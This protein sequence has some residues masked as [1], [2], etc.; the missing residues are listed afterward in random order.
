MP[1]ELPEEF[2]MRDLFIDG[3]N[4]LCHQHKLSLS[5]NR[6]PHHRCPH[7]TNA[8]STSSAQPETFESFGIVKEGGT[9][10]SVPRAFS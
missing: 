2:N 1:Q 4:I 3:L 6:C 10:S 8:P 5:Q 7:R 9:G